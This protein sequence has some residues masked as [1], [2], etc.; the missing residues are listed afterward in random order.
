MPAVY[1]QGAP[2]LFRFE[3]SFTSIKYF[4]LKLK[5]QSPVF[6]NSGVPHDFRTNKTPS[7][8]IIQLLHFLDSLLNQ[9]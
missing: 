2:N 3:S 5:F 1:A 9:M 4:T 7:I 8:I 6:Q